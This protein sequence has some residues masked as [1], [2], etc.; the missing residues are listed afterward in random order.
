[1]PTKRA[2]L[3]EGRHSVFAVALDWPG[4]ARRSKTPE[5]ALEELAN[6]QER[7]EK[8]VGQAL[9]SGRIT[10]VGSVKGNATTDFGAPSALGP[11]DDKTGSRRERLR[12]LEVLERCWRYF[13]DVVDG[14]P[15]KLA[16][17]PRGGGRDRDEVVAH[18]RE[19][20]RA[21]A[22]KMGL[23]IPPR[24]AWV[25]QRSLFL[26]HLTKGNTGHAWPQDYAV[27]RLAWHVVDHAWEI[28][29]KSA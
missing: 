4:W 8:I 11:W 27:R 3:E 12:H 10:I 16:K 28:E 25:E 23:R 20:E 18:V 2:Y 9:A 5:G 14:A 15:K 1:M 17:G 29:D 13:D 19:A 6:Y 26:A 7:Y 24:T 21:Y 22:P